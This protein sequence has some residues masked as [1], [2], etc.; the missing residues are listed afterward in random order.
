MA[1]TPAIELYEPRREKGMWAA[2]AR[3]QVREGYI[4]I[5]A[6]APEA[7]VARQ[8]ARVRALVG[9]VPA[10]ILTEASSVAGDPE[11]SSWLEQ[12]IGTEAVVLLASLL[13]G[14]VPSELA[15]VCS[16]GD[17]LAAGR[18]LRSALTAPEAE[19]AEHE[20]LIRSAL[21]SA[22]G[23]ALSA[24]ASVAR[25]VCASSELDQPRAIDLAAKLVAT[26]VSASPLVRGAEAGD[27]QS[28]AQ[29]ASLASQAASGDAH[30]VLAVACALA[31][32]EGS[33]PELAELGHELGPVDL[34][35]IGG[36]DEN[37][38]IAEALALAIDLAQ[39]TLPEAGTVAGV[40]GA[41]LFDAQL[42]ELLGKLERWMVWQRPV[43]R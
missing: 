33:L 26:C 22:Q 12:A 17:V 40:V 42:L 20:Q 24:V 8:M 41:S 32:E 4:E 19:R 28:S 15:S 36:P 5:V 18:A 21:G 37:A 31:A 11:A 38:E 25:R 35:E 29:L 7:W 23:L 39:S 1:P 2:A 43:R 16:S 30:S 34:S 6:R 9:I 13:I 10:E 27:A 14:A 3:V